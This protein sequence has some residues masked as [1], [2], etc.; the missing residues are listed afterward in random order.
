V[1]RGHFPSRSRAQASIMEGKVRVEGK[2]NAKAGD[3]IP[4]DAVIAIL[5]SD[6]PY[7][8]RGGTKLEG[9]LVDFNI[10]PTSWKALDIGAS[11]GGFT[12]CLLQHGASHVT[13]LDVGK[14][15]I[16]WSLRSDSRVAVIE[17][18]NAR[19]IPP[20]VA[21]GPFDLVVVDVSFI[22]LKLILPNI[23]SRLK[24][25]GVIIALIKPQFEAGRGKAPGGVVVDPEIWRVVLDS[26]KEPAI[27]KAPNPP[28][29]VGFTESRITGHAGNKEFFALW[30]NSVPGTE[31]A[32]SEKK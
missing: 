10:D 20:E 9:A 11:T 6:C 29:L 28:I 15:L 23:P 31:L 8:S 25:E 2:P 21:P 16:A 13:A 1:E 3:R 32:P 7:V 30:R 19:E 17:N 4:D 22:S 12:D 24:S 18:I 5:G 26:F 27:F 14:G